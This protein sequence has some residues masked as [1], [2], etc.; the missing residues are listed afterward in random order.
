MRAIAED[1]LGSGALVWKIVPRIKTL[2]ESVIKIEINDP[3]GR[4]YTLHQCCPT[5]GRMRPAEVFCVAGR[6]RPIKIL[7][8]TYF[9]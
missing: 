1:V 4:L 7:Y 8:F 6:Q 3:Y 9:S 5:R 2:G